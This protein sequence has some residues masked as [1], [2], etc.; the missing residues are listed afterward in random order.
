MIKGIAKNVIQT[1]N[2][3]KEQGFGLGES[4]FEE[5]IFEK[6]SGA[7]ECETIPGQEES[8][9]KAKSYKY[10]DI[11]GENSSSRKEYLFGDKNKH[12]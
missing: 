10:K 5:I 3:V 1:P 2:I 9:K 7:M 12:F 6:N 8:L 4:Q 11:I